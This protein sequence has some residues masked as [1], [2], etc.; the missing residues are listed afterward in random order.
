[1]LSSSPVDLIHFHGLDFWRYLPASQTPALATLHLP[2]SFYPQ[3]TIENCLARG[4]G[5]NCVSHNQ[6]R[7]SAATRDLPVIANGVPTEGYRPGEPQDYLLWLGRICHEKG[8]HIALEIAHRLDRRLVIAGPVHNYTEHQRYFARSIAPL[9]DRTHVYAGPV[10]LGKKRELLAGASC[11][12]IPSLVDE[13]SS[14]VAMEALSS[15]TPVIA[16]RRGALPEV[17]AN[18]LTGFIVNSAGE[19]ADAVAEVPRLSRTLCRAQAVERFDSSRMIEEYL[20]L[21][22]RITTRRFSSGWAPHENL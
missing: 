12:L 13:T 14:L 20:A 16:F 4:I 22:R 17:V 3:E 11:L 10:E 8:P 6:A 15:G 21:Y 5:L 2:V 18:G 7:S 1:V 9:L 19:M